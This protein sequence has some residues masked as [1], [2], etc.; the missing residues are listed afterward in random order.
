MNN[1]VKMVQKQIR[2]FNKA[3][4]RADKAYNISGDIYAA[5]TDLID[6]DRMTNK[7]Y[8]KAGTKYLES[9]SPEELLSYSSDIEQAKNLLEISNLEF[10]L[11]IAG[12]KDPKSLLWKMYDKLDKA[13]YAFDSDQVKAVAD[14]EVPISYKDL[15]VQMNRYLTDDDYGLSDVQAWWDEKLSLED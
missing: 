8:G 3:L 11:D 7:G 1:N 15:A 14:N 10:K 13:G 4:S 6:Y 2:A 5:I 12:V 9:M